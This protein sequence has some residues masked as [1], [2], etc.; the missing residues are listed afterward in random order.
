M[1]RIDVGAHR[2]QRVG[3]GLDVQ[4]VGGDGEIVSLAC[5]DLRKLEAD[6]GRGAGHD[7]QFPFVRFHVDAPVQGLRTTLMQPSFL[8]RNVL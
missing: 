4:L 6:A 5:R 2:S 1:H 3:R 8:S 7:G